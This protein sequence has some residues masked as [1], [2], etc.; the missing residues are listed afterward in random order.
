M[1]GG[2]FLLD[3]KNKAKN[4]KKFELTPCEEVY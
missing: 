2:A 3:K 4:Y 1:L